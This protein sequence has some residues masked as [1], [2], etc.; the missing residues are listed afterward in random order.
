VKGSPFLPNVTRCAFI[1]MRHRDD[2]AASAATTGCFA[3]ANGINDIK[4][5]RYGR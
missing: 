5:S 3:N 1:A 2:P 4:V